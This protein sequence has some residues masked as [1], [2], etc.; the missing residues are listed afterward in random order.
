MVESVLLEV[1]GQIFGHVARAVVAE[2][3]RPVFDSD[4]AKRGCY[5]PK[6][7][8]MEPMK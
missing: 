1:G 4:P 2:Q 3:P 6:F 8:G 5:D 7:H